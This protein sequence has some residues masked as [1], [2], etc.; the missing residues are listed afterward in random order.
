MLKR[1]QVTIFLIV[2]IVLLA[3]FAGIFYLVSKGTT[4][5][6][7]V[8]EE[9]AIDDLGIKPRIAAYVQSCLKEVA[10]PG[11]YLLGMQGGTIFADDPTKA[12]ITENGIIDYGYLN[13]ASGMSLI[14]MEKELNRYIEQNLPI[15]L[16][17]FSE[18]Y[19]ELEVTPGELKADSNIRNN[20]I[21]IDLNYPLQ[22]EKD[23]DVTT[24]KSFSYT[25]SLRLGQMITQAQDII[26]EKNLH[27]D[28]IN[29][30][31]PNKPEF[32]ISSFPFSPDTIIYSISDNLSVIDYAPLTF[33]FAIK[34]DQINS[35]PQLDYIPDLTLRINQEFT[36]QLHANDADQEVLTFYSDA[37]DFPVDETGFLK[38]TPL[39]AGIHVV[40]F[41]V[42]DPKGLE[43]TRTVNIVV[44]NES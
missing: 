27:P 16:G 6:I 9:T 14:E 44:M 40:K 15:C 3:L 43:S 18:F 37:N 41:S 24:V 31:P 29:I 21:V 33:M 30:I 4:S 26:K 13:G 42:K 39:S 34:N 28:S 7:K 36:Y 23:Q 11:I 1:G 25:F 35:P 8:S 22:V 32:F 12:L 17:N 38:V 19:P 10:P 20:D 5:E 2:G